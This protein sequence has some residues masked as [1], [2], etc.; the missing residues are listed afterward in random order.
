MTR[1]EREASAALIQR[2]RAGIIGEGQ[3]L[4]GPYGHV[5]RQVAGLSCRVVVR[6]ELDLQSDWPT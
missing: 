2:I 1:T 4:D 5:G 3:I 6:R